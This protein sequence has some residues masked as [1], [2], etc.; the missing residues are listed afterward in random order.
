[1][2]LSD[3]AKRAQDPAVVRM[4]TDS[5]NAVRA[6]VEAVR[7]ELY[8]VGCHV[9]QCTLDMPVKLYNKFITLNMQLQGGAYAPTRQ[10]GEVYDGL[11]ATLDVQLQALERIESEDL[12]RFNALLERNGL[13]PVH[14]PA[15]KPIA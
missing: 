3:R 11:K 1:M 7:A 10:N 5:A 6:K 13:P 12:A 9:D 14:V 15:R 2:Q 8:E 4:L